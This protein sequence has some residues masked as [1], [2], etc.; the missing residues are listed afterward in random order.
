VHTL[1]IGRTLCLPF[2]LMIL[3]AACGPKFELPE[4]VLSPCD[5][6]REPVGS[7]VQVG[8]EIHFVD[9]TIPGELYGD[10]EAEGCRV[11]VIA[12]GAQLDN[13][14]AQLQ[15]AFRMNAQMVATG[16]LE[17]V[18]LPAHP[19]QLQYVI[20]LASPPS[21]LNESTL[22]DQ[23]A[24]ERTMPPLSGPACDLSS[25]DRMEMVEIQ[26]KIVTVNDNAAAGVAIELNDQGCHVR[27]WVERVYWDEW[28]AEAQARFV[29]GEFIAVEGRLTNVLGEMVIDISDPPH[30]G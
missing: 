2:T 24:D 22:S 3:I 19:D 12:Q 14:R 8:G 28:P 11:G 30:E 10:L 29:V 26:G 18:P 5:V 7:Q 16:R 25:Y 6:E 17:Q 4:G 21:L 23:E 1:K 15:K 9:D 27:L 13:W 20:F